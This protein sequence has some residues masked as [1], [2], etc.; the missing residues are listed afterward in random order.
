MSKFKAGDIVVHFKRD[1]NKIESLDDL[2]YLY[3]IIGEG[4]YT[5][6]GEICYV[7]Q[8]LYGN[9]EIY[10]R[11]STMFES[12]VDTQKYP[13][14][15]Q[16][17]RFE[18]FEGFSNKKDFYSLCKNLWVAYTIN[19]YEMKHCK[20][21]DIKETY[22]VG[23]K[24][25]GNKEFV[26]YDNILGLCAKPTKTNKN[27][28]IIKPT[29]EIFKKLK[30][31]KDLNNEIEKECV[32]T[33]KANEMINTSFL[34]IMK[35]WT[36]ENLPLECLNIPYHSKKKV[37]NQLFKLPNIKN[38]TILQSKIKNLI[39]FEI[40]KRKYDFKHWYIYDYESD[41]YVDENE[42]SKCNFNDKDTFEALE[43]NYSD[44]IFSQYESIMD[45]VAKKFLN[46]NNIDWDELYNYL[47]DFC[48]FLED[49]VKNAFWNHCPLH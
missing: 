20:I 6:T 13:N 35:K 26:S 7:Y 41:I 12:E 45:E 46:Q 1:L 8:A 34:E 49:E 44:F 40:E 2:S 37:L 36:S 15:K 18:K 31:V 42:L 39:N 17:Y 33:Q 3:K 11:P 27:P 4:L 22:V 28:S 5:E 47:F 16:T 32:W 14:A 48:D 21:I 23:K 29:I 38:D 9:N 24:K 19:N 10:I 25:N 43:T 30:L